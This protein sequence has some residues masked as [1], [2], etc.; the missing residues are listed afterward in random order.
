MHNFFF[1]AV[2]TGFATRAVNLGLFGVKRYIVV[3]PRRSK[4]N[5]ENFELILLFMKGFFLI[6]KT[7]FLAGFFA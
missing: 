5:I 2:Y 3:A 7:L 6:S 4:I 1:T